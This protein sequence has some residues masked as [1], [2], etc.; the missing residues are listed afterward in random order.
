MAIEL[1][2]NNI[3]DFVV[4]SPILLDLV[5]DKTKPKT[6][7]SN[8]TGKS[9]KKSKSK[10]A[11]KNRRSSKVPVPQTGSKKKDHFSYDEII[12]MMIEI[13]VEVQSV[14]S[15]NL[16]KIQKIDALI[17]TILSKLTDN[18]AKRLH[19]EH[20]KAIAEIKKAEREKKA[21]GI[22]SIV[23]CVIGCIIGFALGGVG[24]LLIAGLIA[25]LAQSGELNKIQTK[26]AQGISGS[27][28][29]PA[30]AQAVA[31]AIVCVACVV[32]G[33]VIAAGVAGFEAGGACATETI[34]QTTRAQLQE[35]VT[36]EISIEMTNMADTS[37]ED[38]VDGAGTDADKTEESSQTSTKSRIKTNAKL[39]F[40][41]S[42]GVTNIC[43]NAVTAILKACG[44]SK[45]EAEL[46]GTIIGAIIALV[47]SIATMK[48]MPSEG[49]ISSSP[50]IIA[51]VVK[52]SILISALVM[53]SQGITNFFIYDTKKEQAKIEK[54][55][56]KLTALFKLLGI[57]TD[58]GDISKVLKN[59]NSSFQKI[60]NG[61]YSFVA[62][63]NAVAQQLLA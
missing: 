17:K 51:K 57:S 25:G 18:I 24:G 4:H 30:W 6:D 42:L 43:G 22:F 21:M 46:W 14:V 2:N 26:I 5:H 13:I 9:K 60:L 38:G 31:G 3:Q 56:G 47:I 11:H 41:Q 55:M 33:G 54:T 53:L 7:D 58:F 10:K 37:A 12:A 63:K 19:K 35:E 39:A 52:L 59:M 15:Q 48:G 40:I 23:A 61:M 1:N 8:K 27:K 44:V 20:V 16:S 45:K 28:N 50:T 49:M 34:A 62:S 32:A 36:E 29:P